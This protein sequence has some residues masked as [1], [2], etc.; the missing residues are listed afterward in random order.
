[1]EGVWRALVTRHLH[2]LLVREDVLLAEADLVVAHDARAH[3]RRRLP[4]EH[5]AGRSRRERHDARQLQAHERVAAI[6]AARAC[7]CPSSSS[8]SGSHTCCCPRA[9]RR[10]ALW[11]GLRR[12][13]IAPTLSSNIRLLWLRLRLRLRMPSGCRERSAE[14]CVLS[15]GIGSRRRRSRESSISRVGVRVS[16]GVRVG[17]GVGRRRQARRRGRGGVRGGRRGS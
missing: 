11:R 6:P 12:W 1:M 5:E 10:R 2:A 16:V 4:R 7:P 17:V 8:G 13:S 14:E 15:I 9:R 3:A